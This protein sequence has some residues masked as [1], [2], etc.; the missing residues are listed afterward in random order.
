VYPLFLKASWYGGMA[1]SNSVKPLFTARGIFS[2]PIFRV[3]ALA[4]HIQRGVI[5]LLVGFVLASTEV[6]VDVKK[7]H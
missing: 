4:V 3:I 1:A 7:V 5:W 6:K 2:N